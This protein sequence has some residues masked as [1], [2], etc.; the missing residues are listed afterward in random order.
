MA[1]NP[2]EREILLPPGRTLRIEKVVED[3][4]EFPIGANGSVRSNR[5]I[6]AVI[7]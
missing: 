3:G 6:V 7:E 1:Y 4:A 5:H 2:G